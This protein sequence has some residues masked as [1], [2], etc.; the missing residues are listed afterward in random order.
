MIV[1]KRFIPPWEKANKS[2]GM[3]FDDGIVQLGA[4]GE[5]INAKEIKQPIKSPIQK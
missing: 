4:N 2:K 1:R 3:S 5:F